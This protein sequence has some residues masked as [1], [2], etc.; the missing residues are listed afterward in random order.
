V[1]TLDE[2]KRVLTGFPHDLKWTNFRS[3]KQSPSPPYEAQSA[4]S[5]DANWTGAVSLTKGA[6]RIAGLSIKVSVNGPGTRAVPAARTQVDLLRHEQ[7]HYDITGLVA[8]DMAMNLLDLTFDEAVVSALLEAGKTAAT[9]RAYVNGKLK[10]AFDEQLARADALLAKLQT[11]P[12][13]GLAGIYDVQTDHSKNKQAQYLWDDRFAR[14]KRSNA[15]F[16][17]ALTLAGVH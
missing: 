9:R 17:F 13:T 14:L 2:I 6:Y 11:D 4:S 15:S 7:G 8:R 12:Q 5:Y 16:A 10:A 3:E 1:A